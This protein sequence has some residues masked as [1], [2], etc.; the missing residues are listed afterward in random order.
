MDVLIFQHFDELGDGFAF[1]GAF[2]EDHLVEDHTEGPDIGLVG[3]DLPLDDLRGHVD[4]GP[5]HG[6]DHI[7]FVL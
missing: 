5:Q 3:I 1:E 7:I 4:G 2:P 6:I